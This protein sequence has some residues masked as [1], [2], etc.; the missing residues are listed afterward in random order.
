MTTTV[1]FNNNDRIILNPE[2]A[3]VPVDVD[4]RISPSTT[5]TRLSP[6]WPYRVR[7]LDSDNGARIHIGKILGEERR[8]VDGIHTGESLG[9]SSEVALVAYK[10][11][12]AKESASQTP[13]VRREQLL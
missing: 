4:D 8:T 9:L 2:G 12:I 11:N 7:I 10:P 1:I 13:L 5:D 3:S 6:G